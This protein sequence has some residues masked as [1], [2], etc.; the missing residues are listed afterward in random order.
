MT[1]AILRRLCSALVEWL[2]TWDVR[3]HWCW[4]IPNVLTF[5]GRLSVFWVPSYCLVITE[6]YN[7][8]LA[9]FLWGMFTDMVDGPIA[10]KWP[11]QSSVWG[12][13]WDSRADAM[14]GGWTIL[15]LWVSM[16]NPNDYLYFAEVGIAAFVIIK[17]LYSKVRRIIKNLPPPQCKS[18]AVRAKF[19]AY[20]LATTIFLSQKTEIEIWY[21]MFA[22]ISVR[23]LG[24]ILLVICFILSI[25]RSKKK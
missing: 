8:A 15:S 10:R 13:I 20:M 6:Q 5:F 23:H 1:Y 2:K 16:F 4:T 19:F 9:F 18:L 25:I 12:M 17:E 14:F 7:A 3:K 24:D 22:P 11:N 21:D